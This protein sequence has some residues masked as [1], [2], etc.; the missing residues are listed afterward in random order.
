MAIITCTKIFYMLFLTGKLM[1][2]APICSFLFLPKRMNGKMN[3]SRACD[4]SSY[5]PLTCFQTLSI[6]RALTL[7]NRQNVTTPGPPLPVPSLQHFTLPPGLLK[8]H[9]FAIPI[10]NFYSWFLSPKLSF[11]G[12]RERGWFFGTVTETC[13]LKHLHEETLGFAWVPQLK[14]FHVVWD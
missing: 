4:E 7:L 1:F 10:P 6:T 13:G 11:G 8:W 2:L 5:R 12:G 9:Y 3:S 14:N